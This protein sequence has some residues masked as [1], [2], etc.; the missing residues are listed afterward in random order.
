MVVVVVGVL[1][2]SRSTFVTF[3]GE[4]LTAEGVGGFWD[5]APSVRVRKKFEGSRKTKLIPPLVYTLA[6][7]RKFA[8]TVS[9]IGKLFKVRETSIFVRIAEPLI[10]ALG[11]GGSDLT[12]RGKSFGHF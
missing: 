7:A 10:W 1:G 6:L 4:F 2:V 12:C 11:G 5:A 3:N 9:G 8:T